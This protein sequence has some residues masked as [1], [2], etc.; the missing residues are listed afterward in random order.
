[1]ADA[2][3]SRERRAGRDGAKAVDDEA[4]TEEL[5]DNAGSIADADSRCDPIFVTYDGPG[6]GGSGRGD[7]DYLRLDGDSD[8]LD[9]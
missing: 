7:G 6:R 1:M 2:K 3:A 8:V 5:F 4:A 9:T